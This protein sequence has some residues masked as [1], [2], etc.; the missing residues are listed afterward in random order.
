MCYNFFL[1]PHNIIENNKKYIYFMKSIRSKVSEFQN[2]CGTY[3]RI[4]SNIP[5]GKW[6]HSPRLYGP[7]HS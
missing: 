3:Y 5:G 6:E 7:N 1:I 2:S 4:T